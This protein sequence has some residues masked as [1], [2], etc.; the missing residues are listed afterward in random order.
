MKYIG[1][2]KVRWIGFGLAFIGIIQ[3]HSCFAGPLTAISGHRLIPVIPLG[4]R[5]PHLVYRFHAES[6]VGQARVQ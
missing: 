1:L 5:N 6:M 2:R 3:L 4:P